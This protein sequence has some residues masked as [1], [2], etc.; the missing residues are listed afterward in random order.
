MADL[1]GAE[2]LLVARPAATAAVELAAAGA[3]GPLT[4]VRRGEPE[5]ALSKNSEAESQVES[6]VAFAVKDEAAVHVAS[7]ATVVFWTH[8]TC[9]AEVAFVS[10]D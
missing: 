10:R 3:P 5:A 2:A 9:A 1:P 7:K 4:A 8:S 6:V